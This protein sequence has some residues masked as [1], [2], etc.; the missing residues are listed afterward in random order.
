MN[1]FRINSRLQTH[2]VDTYLDIIPLVRW[3]VLWFVVSI[4]IVTVI[5]A[6]AGLFY[7]TNLLAHDRPVE[8]QDFFRGMR[9]YFWQSWLWGGMNFIAA[10]LIF[11][12]AIYYSQDSS[13]AAKIARGVILVVAFLW[14]TIQVYLFPLLLEQEKPR[15][16]LA[17]RNSL[18]L[19]LKRPIYSLGVTVVMVIVVLFSTAFIWPVW[20]VI[21]AAYCA[22]LANK[23]TIQT[24]AKIRESKP[25]S[26]P[27]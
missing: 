21:T 19:I 20:M 5:P 13:I 1:N 18:V 3:N 11:S 23:A 16:G 2:L 24:I 27:S 22:R 15:I 14:V 4:P 6:T 9:R 26:E 12:N 7:V 17:F 10:I 25:S 8:W